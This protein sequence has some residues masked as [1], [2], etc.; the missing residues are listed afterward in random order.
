[1]VDIIPRFDIHKELPF[2]RVYY[3]SLKTGS[4]ITSNYVFWKNDPMPLVLITDF[5][6]NYIRGIN[7]HY[8]TYNYMKSTL[9]LYC[10]KPT[11]N[12]RTAIKPDRFLYNAFRSYKRIGLKNI[13]QLDCDLINEQLLGQKSKYRRLPSYELKAIKDQIRDQLKQIA[14]PNVDDVVAS[15]SRINYITPQKTSS[16][17]QPPEINELQ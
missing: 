16:P 17:Q 4:L 7:L 2:K 10:G 11:F 5:N 1:M 9:S 15:Q 8:L 14:N 3:K 13:H 6:L 12:Y